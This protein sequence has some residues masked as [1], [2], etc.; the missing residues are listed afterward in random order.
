[1]SAE[2]VFWKQWGKRGNCS[3][4]AISPFSHS[5]FYPFEE[6]SAIFIKFVNCRLQALSVWKSLKLVVWERV[7]GWLVNKDDIHL[8]LPKLRPFPDDRRNDTQTMEFASH[9]VEK[10]KRWKRWCGIC[11][12]SQWKKWVLWKIKQTVRYDEQV[13]TNKVK[14]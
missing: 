1:M 6:L 7:K 14:D 8:A 11:Q 9:R 3:W 12:E 10:S 5:V 13:R 4:R 2:Q